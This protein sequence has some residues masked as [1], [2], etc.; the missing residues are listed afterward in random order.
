MAQSTIISTHLHQALSD[1]AQCATAKY[2]ADVARIERGLELAQQGYVT[3]LH[4]QNI[5]IVRS[6]SD[7]SRTYTVNGH[8]ECY[9]FSKA[10]ANRCKHRWSKALLK[11]ASEYLAASYYAHVTPEWCTVTTVVGIA[12]RQA[13]GTWRFR[14]EHGTEIV[15]DANSPALVLGGNLALGEGQE[16]EDATRWERFALP[17]YEDTSAAV[18]ASQ[19]RMAARKQH[20]EARAGLEAVSA[21]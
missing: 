2:P 9:D 18:E 15:Y 19:A 11:K 6:Q 17:Q 5:A 16:Q 20:R 12:R 1:A 4:D 21:L 10:P 3:L 7:A 8:C 13:D 14:S